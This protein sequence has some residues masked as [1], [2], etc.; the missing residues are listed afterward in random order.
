M[1]HTVY[2]FSSSPENM[3][4]IQIYSKSSTTQLIRILST[5]MHLMYALEWSS[6]T[7]CEVI[8]HLYY[9]GTKLFLKLGLNDLSNV[10]RSVFHP[11]DI[12]ITLQIDQC[13]YCGVVVSIKYIFRVVVTIKYY[14][15]EMKDN[16]QNTHYVDLA[17]LRI[18]YRFAYMYLEQLK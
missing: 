17:H 12:C 18:I 5:K 7:S 8:V 6:F 16:K 4:F 1:Q 11:Y 3:A 9:D 14:I 10:E 2:N 13:K 15:I